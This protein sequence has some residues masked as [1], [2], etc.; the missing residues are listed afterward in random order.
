MTR[1][2]P[3]P[4]GGRG[5]EG[6]VQFMA[7]PVAIGSADHDWQASGVRRVIFFSA[8]YLSAEAL[9]IGLMTESSGCNQSDVKFHF[10]P[11]QVWMR[12]HESPR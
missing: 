6:W 12:D 3:L 4:L 2:E 11:S 7:T 8:A 5:R 1:L 10:V 9:T